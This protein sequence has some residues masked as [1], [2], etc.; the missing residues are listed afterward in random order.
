MPRALSLGLVIDLGMLLRVVVAFVSGACVPEKAKLS[1]CFAAAQPVKA[2][3]HRFGALG[4]NGVVGDANGR[5]VVGL[6]WRFGLWPSHFL[7]SL[8]ERDELFRCDEERGE[9]GLGGG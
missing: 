4:D 6:D 7:E 5:G 9:F 8:A 3:I 1:L 2:H